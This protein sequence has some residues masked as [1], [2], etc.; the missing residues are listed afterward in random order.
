MDLI[1]D[2]L[3]GYN[4]CIFAYGATGSG[5]TY[6]ML[7]KHGSKGLTERSLEHI[8][9]VMD[10]ES[11]EYSFQILASYVEIYNENIRDLLNYSKGDYLDLRDDPNKGLVIAG[12]Q[13][14]E[15]QSIDEVSLSY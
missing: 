5:K 10:E 8:F 3:K 4:A 7:G 1:E 14:T 12:V 9:D 11:T 13:K 15:V 6:T 2:V